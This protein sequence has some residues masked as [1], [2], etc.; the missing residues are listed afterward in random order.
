MFYFTS[1]KLIDLD[2]FGRDKTSLVR[3]FLSHFGRG[4]LIH[5]DQINFPL[6]MAEGRALCYTL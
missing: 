6:S 4:V 1:A 2:A 3:F 5:L